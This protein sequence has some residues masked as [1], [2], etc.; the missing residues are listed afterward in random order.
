M[1]PL[2]LPGHSHVHTRMASQTRPHQVDYP[3]IRGYNPVQ[4]D[5]SDFTQSRPP[6]GDIGPHVLRT[7]VLLSE[8]LFND[9]A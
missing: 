4:D 6:E 7:P 5:Q 9:S 8:D 2:D 1:N 3:L